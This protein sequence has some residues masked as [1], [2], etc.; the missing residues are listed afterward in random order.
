MDWKVLEV[1]SLSLCFSI[2]LWLSTYL[3]TDLSVY[4]SIC[5]SVYLSLPC[6][7]LGMLWRH[8]AVRQEKHVGACR[9]KRQTRWCATNYRCLYAIMPSEKTYTLACNELW[10]LLRHRAVRKDKHEK[11]GPKA[12]YQG[13]RTKSGHSN[14]VPLL[15]DASSVLVS[16]DSSKRRDVLPRK[17]CP[18]P[19]Y[20]PPTQP[21]IGCNSDSEIRTRDSNTSV[22]PLPAAPHIY[23]SIYLSICLSVC[24]SICLSTCLSVYLSVCLSVCLSICL[25]IYLSLRLSIDQTVSLSICLPICPSTCLCI[26]LSWYLSIYLSVCLSVYLS[27]SLSLSSVYLSSCLP[28]YLPIYL[29]ICL[30]TCLSVV[31]CHSV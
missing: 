22:E 12:T 19:F 9:Q 18:V 2:F 21:S 16:A 7:E 27:L 30:S 28:V 13:R 14:N 1:S 29:S 4:L 25:S 15:F 20:S 31:Q 24:L 6:N 5:L 26:Y 10:M 17:M 3:P 11:A 8:R 23:L